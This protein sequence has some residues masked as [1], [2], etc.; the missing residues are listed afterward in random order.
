MINDFYTLIDYV[1]GVSFIIFGAATFINVNP[2]L[3]FVKFASKSENGTF[4]YA[5]ASLLLP[6]GLVIIFTHN[7]WTLHESIIVTLVG[8]IL[9]I[10]TSLWILVPKYMRDIAK[11]KIWQKTTFLR[12]VGASYCIL[13]VVIM[14]PYFLI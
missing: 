12:G 3:Q 13:G 8:W 5:L 7:D 10:K 9:T 11:K 1:V 6:V 4:I 2:A 14:Y